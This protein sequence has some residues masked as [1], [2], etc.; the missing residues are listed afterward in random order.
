[1]EHKVFMLGHL[2]GINAFDQWGVELGKA[3]ARQ[4]LPALEE[5]GSARADSFDSATRALIEAIHERRIA[6]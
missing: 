4:I 2:W 3:I 6:Q 5:G 1:Y